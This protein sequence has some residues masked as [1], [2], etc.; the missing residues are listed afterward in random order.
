[1]LKKILLGITEQ[2]EEKIEKM[3]NKGIYQNRTEAIRD[4]I[5]K[6]LEASE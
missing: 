2:Q 4:A 3:I 6:L 1:M 5:R